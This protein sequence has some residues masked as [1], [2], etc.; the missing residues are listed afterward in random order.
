MEGSEERV[1]TPKKVVNK[2]SG[3]CRICSCSFLVKYG[4]GKSGRMSTENLFEVS[5]RDGSR[6]QVLVTM[7]ENIGIYFVKLSSLSSRVCNSCARKIRNLCRLFEEIRSATNFESSVETGSSPARIK[8]Q[9]PTTVSTPDRSPTNRKV[10]RSSTKVEEVVRI[11][12]KFS[13]C[14]LNEA[15]M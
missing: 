12:R 8:R 15:C 1:L 9:L 14:F 10:S 4:T 11:D 2:A 3:H 6:G 7:C 5:N 13:K